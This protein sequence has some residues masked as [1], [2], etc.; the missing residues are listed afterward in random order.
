MLRSLWPILEKIKPVKLLVINI[1]GPEW[2]WILTAMYG[3][4]MAAVD[5][6]FFK[7]RP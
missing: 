6:Q 3:T 2:L 4:V 1:T 7:T 5:L